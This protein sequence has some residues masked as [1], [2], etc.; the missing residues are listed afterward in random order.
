MS[1]YIFFTET[2]VSPGNPNYKKVGKF[3]LIKEEEIIDCLLPYLA[4]S[5][6]PGEKNV[7]CSVQ[8]WTEWRTLEGN[9]VTADKV[10]NILAESTDNKV[11]VYVY[12]SSS[13]T[14]PRYAQIKKEITFTKM[15]IHNP[16]S[17][18]KWIITDK[19][20]HPIINEIFT[21]A[22]AIASKIINFRNINEIVILKL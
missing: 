3:G 12:V 6:N 7:N 8:N 1:N 18:D 4:L 5:F 9:A 14:N 16:D 2:K 15:D 21:D 19:Y 17:S 11:I 22:D 13:A 10:I 20:K